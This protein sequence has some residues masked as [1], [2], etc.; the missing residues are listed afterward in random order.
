MK[1]IYF[2][3]GISKTGTSFLQ[4]VFAF[5]A[6][7]YEKHDLIY[8]DIEKNFDTAIKGKAILE[9]YFIGLKRS[10]FLTDLI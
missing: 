9:N 2:H 10:A 3:I 1:T 6:K 5:N 4:T 8:L 7:N